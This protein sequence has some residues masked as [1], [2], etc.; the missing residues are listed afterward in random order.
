[1]SGLTEKG[2]SSNDDDDFYDAVDSSPQEQD[3]SYTVES[4]LSKELAYG[5]ESH[6]DLEKPLSET[7][8]S[9]DD[10]QVD[11]YSGRFHEEEKSSEN[12][13][14]KLSD[15]ATGYSGQLPD[16]N[17]LKS[18]NNNKEKLLDENATGNQGRFPEDKSRVDNKEKFHGET[19]TNHSRRSPDVE[20]TL[21]SHTQH[22]T[23]TRMC[24]E[25]TKHDS[26]I[27]SLYVLDI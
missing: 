10:N 20:L 13:Q 19:D 15:T 21:E 11:I 7:I 17:Y 2:E 18:I 8:K 23:N 16:D 26:E 12:N 3:T 6:A 4:I 1:M 24:D 14:E 9:S 5:R 27:V 22:G 25:T